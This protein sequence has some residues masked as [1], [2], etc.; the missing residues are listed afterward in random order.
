MPD[1]NTHKVAIRIERDY[2]KRVV[3]FYLHNF[4]GLSVYS[5]THIVHKP[6][7]NT[8]YIFSFLIVFSLTTHSLKAQ[9]QKVETKKDSLN[10]NFSTREKKIDDANVP[11]YLAL[12]VHRRFGK[13]KRL[14]FYRGNQL[15]FKLKGGKDKYKA[16][17]Q[18]VRTDEIGILG[19]SIPFKN[20]DK[21][22]VR[23]PNWFVHAGSVL[24]PVAGIGYFAMD[25][26]NPALDDQSGTKPFTIHREAVIISSTLVLS[27]IILRFFKRRIYK[28]N[29]RRI[30]RS[31]IKF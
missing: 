27:G 22:I 10:K 28:I 9:E 6:M 8:V 31:M 30:L 21:I 20:I 26:I 3:F 14:R 15:V 16:N 18:D 7:N 29:K 5:C 1:C 2:L 12:D 25:M 19:G 17:I 13:V 11:R 4:E 24:F 23:N